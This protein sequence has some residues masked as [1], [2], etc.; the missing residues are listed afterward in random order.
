MEL[1]TKRIEDAIVAD[2]VD[3]MI[4]DEEFRARTKNEIT[5]RIDKL[6]KD[7]AEAEVRSTVEAAIREGFDRE[8]QRTD[9]FGRPADGPKTTIR[10]E[11]ERLIAGYWNEN[12]GKDGKPEGAWGNNK[13]TRAEWMMTKIVAADFSKD[14]QQHVANLGGSLKDKL[15]DSLRATLDELLSTVFK[16]RSL[17]DQGADRGKYERLLEEKAPAK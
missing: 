3:R 5:A 15:R 1:D 8:Y 9:S 7:S 10:A 13:M 2:V 4:G 11:L 17:D 16:V 14:M 12:V 6:W